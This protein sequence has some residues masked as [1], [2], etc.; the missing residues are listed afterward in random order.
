MPAI[1]CQFVRKRPGAPRLARPFIL[2][3]LIGL[4]KNPVKPAKPAKAAAP[5]A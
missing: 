5:D 4:R 2:T 1:S 3:A